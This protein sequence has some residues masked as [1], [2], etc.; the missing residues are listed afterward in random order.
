MRVLMI[1]KALVVGL[2]QRKLELLAERG[3]D[4]L[5][6]TPPSWRDERGELALERAY[7]RGYSLETLPIANSG[8]FHLHFY[9]GLGARLR[10]FQPDLVHIDEEPY[11]LA[12]WQALYHARRAGAKTIAF[13]W[14]NLNRRYPPPFAWGERWMLNR[15]DGLIAGTD[16]AAEVWRAKGYTGPLTVIA[17]FGTDGALFRPAETRPDRPFTF[18]YFGRLVEE[19][20]IRLLLDACAGLDGDWRL[21]LL[22]GGPLRGELETRAQQ[23]GMSARVIFQPQVPSTDMPLWYHQIDALA[24]PSLTR[25]NW[26]EQFGRVLVEAMASG[27]PVLGSDSGAIPGVIGSA[28]LVTPE[29]DRAALTEAL[30]RLRE[31][32]TLR[33]EL[34]AQGRARALA[35]FSHASVADKTVDFYEN[36]V[37]G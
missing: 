29:G 35:E 21:L 27:V 34:A 31:D 8:D 7:T 22:G 18:G 30:R 14:Q 37:N 20:G 11:N 19:K 28:G 25:P 24:L 1:S 9:R 4:L 6:I 5:A 16:S 10:D 36:I 17:Q 15:I 32:A 26:K 12:A 23:L 33:A 13:S 2:Y 3:I